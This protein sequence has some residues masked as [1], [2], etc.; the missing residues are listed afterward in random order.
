[1][2]P[3]PFSPRHR[4]WE[5]MFS[6]EGGF[7][8]KTGGPVV[9][10]P[11]WSRRATYRDSPHGEVTQVTPWLPVG[12]WPSPPQKPLHTPFEYDTPVNRPL[13][14]CTPNNP[15]PM[16]RDISCF[17]RRAAD[18]DSHGLLTPG[19]LP[20]YRSRRRGLGWCTVRTARPLTASRPAR[21]CY[22]V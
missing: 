7:R 1:M 4:Q 5:V 9:L 2:T 13:H 10:I 12:P 11:S 6:G 21:P 17:P 22:G 15:I 19:A 16:P 20:P 14:P 18:P 8:S 3:G